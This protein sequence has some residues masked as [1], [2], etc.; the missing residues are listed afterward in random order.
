[1]ALNLDT[2]CIY[3]PLGT[4][5][6]SGCRNDTW[7]LEGVICPDAVG[8]GLVDSFHTFDWGVS[9]DHVPLKNCKVREQLAHDFKDNITADNCKKVWKKA[10]N[11]SL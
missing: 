6:S 7:I 1:M 11:N 9:S 3:L 10:E 4:K 8:N 2:C 5:V